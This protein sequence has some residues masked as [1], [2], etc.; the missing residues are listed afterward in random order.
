MS[1]FV[2]LPVR[3]LGDGSI[4]A[5]L[6]S[7]LSKTDGRAISVNRPCR[8]VSVGFAILPR[9]ARQGNESFPSTAA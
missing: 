2:H 8:R 9:N 3:R 5:P 6:P 1:R 4:G 7:L